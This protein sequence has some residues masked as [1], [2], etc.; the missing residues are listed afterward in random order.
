MPLPASQNGPDAGAYRAGV[1]AGSLALRRSQRSLTDRSGGVCSPGRD[2]PTVVF[3]AFVP[4][5]A[6]RLALIFG[7]NKY[8]LP[9]FPMALA[10]P[11]LKQIR[12]YV[13]RRSLFFEV[14]N[15]FA[16]SGR[17]M[18]KTTSQVFPNSRTV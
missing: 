4:V 3:G 2:V 13:K 14:M 11:K 12:A 16:D 10:L 9:N 7:W 17:W 5:R 18:P 6:V 15:A 1:S 8:P